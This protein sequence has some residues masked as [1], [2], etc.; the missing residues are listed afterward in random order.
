[1]TVQVRAQFPFV[2]IDGTALRDDIRREIVEVWVDDHLVLPDSVFV[3]LRF[4]D[5]DL[6]SRLG[7]SIGQTIDIRAGQLGEA[8]ESTLIKAEITSIE[9]VYEYGNRFLVIRGYDASHRLQIGRKTRSFNNVTDSDLARRI[10]SD[11]GLSVGTIDSTTTVHDHVSQINT[12]DWEFLRWRAQEI[13]FKVAVRDGQFS[14]TAADA[15]GGSGGLGGT[16]GGLLGGG[17]SELAVGQGLLCFR[18]RVTGAQQVSRVEAR[19]WD[20]ARKQAVT[21]EADAATSSVTLEESRWTPTDLADVFGGQPYLTCERPIATADEAQALAESTAAL[22]ASSFAEAEGTA[23]GNPAVVTGGKLTISGAGPFDGEYFVSHA[24]HRFDESGYHTDF[25]VAG[26]QERSLLGLSSLGATA[27]GAPPIYGAVVALVT[28]AQDPEKIGRVK[29]EFPWLSDDYESD[30]ARVAYP[31]AGAS[32]GFF[33]TPEVGDEVLV[34]FE[35]GDM[36]RPYVLGGLY[37]GVDAPPFDGYVDGSDGGVKARRWTSTKG[38]E[39]AI[40]E[41][42][43]DDSIVLT[44]SNGGFRITISET[45]ELIEVKSDA[46]VL[47]EASREIELKGGDIKISGTSVTIEADGNLEMSG[48]NAKLEGSGQTEVKGGIVKLN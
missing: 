24:R 9:A 40:S 8:A 23:E 15:G 11:A 44:S 29:V 43:D 38:H 45:D 37:N 6:W 7:V 12:T 47:V 16:A 20:M 32:R 27:S 30:W 19:G 41:Q 39:I 35:R 34:V 18:P 26:H 5:P 1:M 13:G 4:D 48:A 28:N 31:G 46:K 36:R 25:E 21:H 3:R 17:E 2:G 33:N 10:A 22:I 42:S 14:F